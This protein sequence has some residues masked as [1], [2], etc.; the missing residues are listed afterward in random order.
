M[1]KERNH[2]DRMTSSHPTSKEGGVEY[3]YRMMNVEY[4]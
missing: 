4:E 2:P 3:E 1:R